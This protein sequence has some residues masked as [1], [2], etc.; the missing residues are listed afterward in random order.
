MA[1]IHLALTASVDFLLLLLLLLFNL[2]D[3]CADLAGETSTG[4]WDFEL[5][6]SSA[7]C[8]RII[9]QTDRE[10]RRQGDRQTGRQTDRETDRDREREFEWME[11]PWRPMASEKLGNNSDSGLPISGFRVQ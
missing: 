1:V 10:T 8:G 2:A 5:L 6:T 3:V 7:G 11:L 9:T 4:G